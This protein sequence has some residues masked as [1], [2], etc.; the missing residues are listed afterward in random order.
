VYTVATMEKLQQQL[1]SE[2]NALAGTEASF[3]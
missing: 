2:E 3:V 1:H